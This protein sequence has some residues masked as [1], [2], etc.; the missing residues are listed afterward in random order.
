MMKTIYDHAL[1]NMFYITYSHDLLTL[2]IEE[3]II[4]TFLTLWR[5]LVHDRLDTRKEISST[6]LNNS[7]AF[8]AEL[9]GNFDEMFLQYY[10]H[11]P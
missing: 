10:I 2:Y 1:S 7:E 4:T 6:L 5:S 9:L 3:I 8:T 11:S